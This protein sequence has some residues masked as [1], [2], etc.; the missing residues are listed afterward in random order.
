MIYLI[1]ISLDIVKYV[2]SYVYDRTESGVVGLVDWLRLGY[3][4]NR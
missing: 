2:V 1:S 4:G 3:L